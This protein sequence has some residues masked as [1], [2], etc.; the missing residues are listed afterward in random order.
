[1]AVTKTKYNKTKKKN[2]IKVNTEYPTEH[3]TQKSESKH[4]KQ[5]SNVKM[6]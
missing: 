3:E 5:N 6:F 2:I 4:F 1:M